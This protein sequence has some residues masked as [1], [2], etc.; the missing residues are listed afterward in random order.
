MEGEERPGTGGGGG[1]VGE[2][3]EENGE[4]SRRERD[5]LEEGETYNLVKGN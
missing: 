5:G 1:R 2:K 3:G 4:T